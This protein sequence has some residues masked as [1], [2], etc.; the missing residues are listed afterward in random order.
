MNAQLSSIFATLIYP[1]KTCFLLMPPLLKLIGSST[2]NFTIDF[3]DYL[4]H[5]CYYAC[6]RIKDRFLSHEL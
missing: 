3:D 5:A 4:H 6:E 1:K 2:M